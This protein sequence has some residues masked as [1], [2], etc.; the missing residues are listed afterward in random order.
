V[1]RVRRDLGDFQ[2]P[3]G[4]VSEVLNTLGPIGDRWTRVLE[5]TCGRGHFIAGLLA[6][7]DRPREIQGIEIQETHAQA[8][9]AL[10]QEIG[11]GT[12]HLE[13]AQRDLFDLDIGRD[14][15]WREQGPLLVIGNPPWVTNS[16]L[17]SL[18]GSH[19]PPRRNLKGLRGLDA[20][21]GSSNF[22]VAEAIWLKL[23]FELVDERPTIALLCKTSVARSVLQFSRRAGLSIATAS[24]R[25]IDAARWFGAAVDACWFCV[26]LGHQTFPPLAKGGPGGVVQEQFSDES[27]SPLRIPV[28]SNLVQSA[29]DNV[30][31]FAGEWLVADSELHARFATIDGACPLDWRQGLKH[32]AAAV[33]ELVRERSSSPWRNRDGEP[34]DVEPEFVYPLVKGTDLTREPANRPERAILVT[35]KRLGEKTER[36]AHLAPRLWT[37][38]QS[39]VASFENRKSSIYRG[40]PPFSLFGIGPYSFARYK[41]AISGMHKSPRFVVLGPIGGKG[42]ML[43]D[44]CYFL[45]CS[46]AA[47]ASILAALCNN[48][49][50]LGL[51]GS[52]SFRDAK[53]PITKR[54]LQRIDL[55][56]L[57]KMTDRGSLLAGAKKALVD[58]LSRS[59]D[60]PVEQAVERLDVAFRQVH[61]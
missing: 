9:R 54:L 48:P 24:I 23:A 30:M 42:A 34:V 5:P 37:Y 4:L 35:Q 10:A 36:L 8:A 6:R 28:F 46:T 44:T 56:T 58:E 40:Q 26:T 12:V 11:A 61:K 50:T 18:N 33:M 17:G 15:A 60:E 47:E 31:G 57:L 55:R 21:T 39:H 16:E 19:R 3:P 22:D 43:D 25:R 7:T 38:L 41:V 49:I 45:P 29:P 32:D 59:P 2:T 27:I 51:I 14:V 53:R 52:M 13:I 20:R 1:I